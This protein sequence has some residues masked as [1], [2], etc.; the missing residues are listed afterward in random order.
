[1]KA[2]AFAWG[3]R[4]VALAK[5]L[6]ASCARFGIELET[7]TR[8]GSPRTREEAWAVR[9]RLLLEALE[10]SKEPLLYLDADA[11]LRGSLAALPS[12]DSGND[13]GAVPYGDGLWRVGV[14]WIAPTHAARRT[15]RAMD[16]RLG[17]EGPAP[18]EPM[19]AELSQAHGARIAELPP[20]YN[21]CE[22]WNDRGRHGNRVPVV[23]VNA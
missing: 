9:P 2:L 6:E 15:L 4:Y 22:A 18:L 21:W 17:L 13:F 14:W 10:G 16:A 3:P 23:E 12:A 20:E 5:R 7:R 8:A 11:Q 19:F 1:M